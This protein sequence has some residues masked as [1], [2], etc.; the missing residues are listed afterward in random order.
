MFLALFSKTATFCLNIT[1]SRFY[2]ER[3]NDSLA[4]PRALFLEKM[5]FL[6][7]N[8]LN[9]GHQTRIDGCIASQG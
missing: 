6:A 8:L 5:E 7:V 9:P 3:P 4:L 1:P 2:K